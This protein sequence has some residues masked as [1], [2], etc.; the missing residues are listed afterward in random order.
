MHFSTLFLSISTWT[1]FVKIHTKKDQKYFVSQQNIWALEL[2]DS[3]FTAL[4]EL[5]TSAQ[6]FRGVFILISYKSSYW[7]HL[8]S[9]LTSLP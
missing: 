9:Q 4:E 7:K 1:G 8:G 5:A 6:F 2:T 3:L